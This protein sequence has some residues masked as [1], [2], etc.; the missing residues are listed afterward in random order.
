[1]KLTRILWPALAGL[2]LLLAPGCRASP[3]SIGAARRDS[4][5]ITIVDLPDLATAKIPEWTTRVLFA[6]DSWDIQ[7]LSGFT[8]ARILADSTVLLT[9]SSELRHIGPSGRL[10]GTIGRRGSGPG[11]YNLPY[12]LG[13]SPAGDILVGDFSNQRV[14]LLAPTLQLRRVIARLT[15]TD[16]E[17]EPIGLLDRNRI[18]VSYWQ[19]RPSR[20]T[21]GLTVGG[22]HR[23]SAP[24]LLF[25]SLGALQRR[26]GTWPGLERVTV[27][28]GM[29]PPAF[30][31]T[32]LVQSRGK[33]TAITPTDSL[34]L[35]LFA[36]TAVVLQLRGG[37]RGRTPTQQDQQAFEAGIQDEIPDL[38]EPYLK[39]MRQAATIPVMPALGALAVD[40]EGNSWIGTT[41]GPA[42][43]LRHW[44]VVSP[45]GEL[46]GRLSLPYLVNQGIPGWREVLD[47]AGN[48]LV[49]LRESP[50]GEL[51]VEL[52]Q[53]IRPH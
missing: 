4:A 3:P 18:L 12:R 53:V 47:V 30:A 8:D 21:P 44:T 42:D 29:A 16:Y 1:M 50:E 15:A 26:L 2:T 11:E 20:D 38:F 37:A 14:T 24:L 45:R 35:T 22:R 9:G 27:S 33:Y 32:T 10:L 49:L 52:R 39:A 34:A 19:H 13:I 23:D 25:D 43:S 46:L 48:R 17:L 28:F 7:P 40:D 41:P 51:T 36:D 31:R 6:S 5:G